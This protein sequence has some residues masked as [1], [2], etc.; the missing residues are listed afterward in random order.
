M[1]KYRHIILAMGLFISQ[2]LSAQ[3]H[4]HGPDDGGK[5]NY[6]VKDARPL[7]GGEL[8]NAGEYKLEV[9]SRVYETNEKICVYVIRRKKEVA[10]EGAVGEAELNYKNGQTETLKMELRDNR[11]VLDS[12]NVAQAANITFRI[13]FKGK[14]IS[15]VY[16]YPGLK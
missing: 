5:E 15:S 6:F 7:H 1:K 12:F 13:I 2:F 9:V 4:S 8:L 14:T 16:R 10:L 11:L 3:D